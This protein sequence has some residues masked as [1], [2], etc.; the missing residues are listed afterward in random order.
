MA[1]IALM[2]RISEYAKSH[3]DLDVELLRSGFELMH[4]TRMIEQLVEAW[5]AE[6]DVNLRLIEIMECLFHH[7]D[8]VMT[9]AD[10]SDEVNL[11]RSAMTSALDSLEKLGYAQRDPYPNDRRML[12]VS[13]TESGREYIAAWLPDRYKKFSLVLESI[14]SNERE[15]L[16]RTYR[17]VFE[18][19]QKEF[20]NRP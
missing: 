13:L 6:H 19:L 18:I 12:E 3:C 2:E 8:G 4:L 7:P 10:L 1:S 15:L 11:S 17:K 5:L 14:S 20:D 9:P 16:L